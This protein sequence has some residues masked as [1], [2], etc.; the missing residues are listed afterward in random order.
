MLLY[1]YIDFKTIDV[2]GK[3][4]YQINDET[5]YP[6]ITMVLGNTQS[7]DKKKSLEGSRNWLGK[8]K[9]DLVSKQATDRGTNVHTMVEQFL[10]KQP[11]NCPNATQNDISLFNSLKLKLKPINKIYGQ[12]VVLYSNLIEI[13]GRC[14]FIGEYDGIPVIADWK[15]SSKIKDINMIE[16][17]FIQA[18]FYAI[19]HN[20]MFGTDIQNI[21]IFIAV[22]N[23][24]PQVFKKSISND[25]VDKL[26]DK[27]EKF[28][29]EL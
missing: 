1:N 15:T 10:K 5:F 18:S 21:I 13:A 19:A 8:D 26:M 14:D 3:R 17:Y 23:S 4:F 9:A 16:D 22:E 20:E 12:E 7:E 28:Y 27:A 25:Y 24:L 29:K 11:I 2:N 6:S